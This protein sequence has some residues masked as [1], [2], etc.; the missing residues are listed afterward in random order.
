MYLR[1]KNTM[2]GRTGQSDALN[3]S[4]SEIS[5]EIVGCLNSDDTFQPGTFYQVA[6]LIVKSFRI[7]MFPANFSVVRK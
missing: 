2:M 7:I 5:G 3:K 1:Q 6:I 4:F